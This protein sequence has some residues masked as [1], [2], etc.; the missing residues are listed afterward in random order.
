MATTASKA[1]SNTA[2]SDADVTANDSLSDVFQHMQGA[3]NSVKAAA[4][5][6]TSSSSVAAREAIAQGKEKA[7]AA[8]NQADGWVKER[9]YTSMGLAFAAGVVLTGLLKK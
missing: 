5:T 8:S 9:P 7:Y 2:T 3:A 4:S 6:L 1:K